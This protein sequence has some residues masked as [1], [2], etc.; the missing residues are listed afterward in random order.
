MPE[1][2]DLTDLPPDRWVY[3][4]RPR[5]CTNCSVE[6]EAGKKALFFPF[7]NNI[8][9]YKCSR[10]LTGKLASDKRRYKRGEYMP[11]VGG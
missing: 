1:L 2:P 3:L 5:Y 4:D 6:I 8:Y 7:T 9:C 10:L 11:P